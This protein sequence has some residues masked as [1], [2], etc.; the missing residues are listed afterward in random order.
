MDLGGKQ[1]SWTGDR[2]EFVGR[3]GSLAA[4]RAVGQTL[5][6]MVG[7]GL[8][9]CG[10]LRTMVELPPGGEVELTLVL[11]VAAD[12]G[13]ARALV[14]YYRSADLDVVLDAVRTQWAQVLGAIEVKTPDRSM[15]IMLNGWLLYQ[16]VASR[17]WGRAG[18]Y[19]ASGA[20][21]FR[22]QLQD[23][24]ALCASRPDLVR[25]HLLRAAGRQFEAGDVQHWWLPVTGRGVRTRISDD[26]AWLAYTVA[27]YVEATG[28]N[29]VLNEPVGYL[30]GP[31]LNADE[32]DRFFLPNAAPESGPL[33]EHCARAL[34]HSLAVGSHGLPLMG[35]GDWNDGMNRIGEAGRGKSVWLGW[36]LHA[37]LTA[38]IPLADA[39]ADTTR[40]TARRAHA[41]AILPALERSW[42][43][44]WYLRA[45]HDD[46]TPL[47]S[48]NDEQCMIDSI[49]QSWG[50]ISGV[51]PPGHAA[52]AM[53]SLDRH[54]VRA[55]DKL[56]L[57]LTPPFDRPAIDPGYIAGYPPGIRENGGQY[58]HAA[59]WAVLAFTALGDG[60]K[61]GALFAMLNPIN[62][63]RTRA[64][65]ERYKVEPYAVVADIYSTA[66]HVGRGGWSWYTGSAGWMQRVGVEGILGVR[67]LGTSLH[68]NPCI[69][70]HWPGF[71]ATI[72]WRS[73]RYTITVDNPSGV[74]QG[75]RS[76]LLDGVVLPGR[77]V[78][79][80][81]DGAQHTLGVTLGAVTAE[82]AA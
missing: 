20:Y 73:A 70:H 78:A 46:G 41:A 75:V 3:N 16:T 39:R 24:L 6:G 43:G 36:F 29:A 54:L 79:L 4:P 42:D 9:P 57:V 15:D 14:T 11:G 58:T 77:T 50:V 56:V 38:F 8:D 81:D 49:A 53:A 69:P 12:A 37:A 28:D 17:I 63:A 40:A 66:P 68:I 65:A 7:A 80:A 60:D 5:S 26:C 74:S 18:F 71:T 23:G 67:I 62:H 76:I 31:P 21:G 82:Q 44:E 1:T 59:T 34:D 2:R 30:T 27:H 45:Y 51:A 55:Y 25:Q 52:R 22:D 33:Y 48:H 64:D 13:A 47:G 72:T 32:H 10:A 35:T 61:A 19:Q